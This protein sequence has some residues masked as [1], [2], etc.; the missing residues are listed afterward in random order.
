[1]TDC[2]LYRF[3]GRISDIK[4][5]ESSNTAHITFEKQ[6]AAK[7][8]LM[9]NG[10]TLDGATIHVGSD[11]VTEEDE[12]PTT[13]ERDHI[14]QHDK[15]RAGIVAEMLAKGYLLTDTILH[16]AIEVD[17]KQVR[18]DL[19][20]FRKQYSELFCLPG[21]FY[22]FHQLHPRSRRQAGSRN[23]RVWNQGLRTSQT[24]SGNIE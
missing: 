21:Y 10:G 3:C 1:V 5:D 2:R 6:Q 12:R 8:A 14:E 17:E 22:S 4:H 24:T 23:R 18:S 7:T 11:S 19:C 20:S 9:L 15:P 16:K 13:A